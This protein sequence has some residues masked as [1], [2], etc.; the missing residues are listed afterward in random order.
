[1]KNNKGR[2]KTEG[3]AEKPVKN[4]ETAVTSPKQ[5]KLNGIKKK[6]RIK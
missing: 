6:Q 3:H 5:T 1:M 4:L 2:G